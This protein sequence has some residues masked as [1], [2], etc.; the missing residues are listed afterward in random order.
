ML[1]GLSCHI[2]KVNECPNL[3]SGGGGVNVRNWVVVTV[4]A[5]RLLPP[6][7]K[8]SD[9]GINGRGIEPFM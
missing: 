2:Y 5:G 3:G 8:R 4:G 7:I 9:E 1:S 6:K